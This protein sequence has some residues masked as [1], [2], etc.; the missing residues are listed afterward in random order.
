MVPD[1]NDVDTKK[2]K[3]KKEADR[4]DLGWEFDDV[5]LAH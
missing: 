2:S 4:S 1:P 5:T 3:T